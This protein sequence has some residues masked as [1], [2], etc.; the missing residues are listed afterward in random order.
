MENTYKTAGEKVYLF[1]RN[2]I[3]ELNIKPGELINLQE[4]AD[5]LN[6]S[7]SPIR[8]ALMQLENEGL[9]ESIIKKGTYVSKIDLERVSNERF[10]RACIE[11]RL[12]KIFLETYTQE[13]IEEMEHCIAMQEIAL[14]KRN[15]RD[16]LK[17]DDEF[18]AVMYKVTNYPVC[19]QMIQN[20][21][22]HYYRIRLLSMADPVIALSIYEQHQKMLNWYKEKNQSAL[23]QSIDFHI[24]DKNDE[25]LKLQMHYP[26]LFS[27]FTSILESQHTILET[28]FLKQM[29]V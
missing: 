11:T 19:L 28:D 9:V 13:N 23:E 4:L 2:K 14:Q 17:W 5:I 24:V 16:L 8:D 20:F 10:M 29:I 27:D 18:H 7:R 22:G 3:I 15:P 6:V 26:D 25:V 12:V 21:S 1:L